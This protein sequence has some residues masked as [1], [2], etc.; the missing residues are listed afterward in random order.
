MKQQLLVYSGQ[1]E[2][3]EY[4]GVVVHEGVLVKPLF[5]YVGDFE[6]AVLSGHIPVSRPTTL[7]AV[8][9]VRII[10]ATGPFTDY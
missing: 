8:G 2:V 7:G 3:I 1:L 10:E 9:V 5:I 4:P 6:K